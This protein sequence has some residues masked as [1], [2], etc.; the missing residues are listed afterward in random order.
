MTA[1]VT[2]RDPEARPP[3]V[4]SSRSARVQTK[5]GRTYRFESA[6]HLPLLPEGHKCKN[7]HGHNYR[8]DVVVRGPLD[9][10]GFVK[11]FAELDAEIVP[12][13]KILDHQLLNALEGVENQTAKLNKS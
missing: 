12:L 8:I 13:I 10:R 11:D 5:I 7:I 6:H 9:G 4:E 3:A 1:H 2:P